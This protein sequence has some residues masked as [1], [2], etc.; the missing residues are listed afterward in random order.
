MDNCDYF[1]KVNSSRLAWSISTEMTFSRKTSIHVGG[2]TMLKGR[3]K[4]MLG[5]LSGFYFEIHIL[6]VG[7]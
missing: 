6:L 1:F 2:K 7:K 5:T 4:E 3:R